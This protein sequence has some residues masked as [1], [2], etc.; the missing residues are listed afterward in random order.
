MVTLWSVVYRQP[1]SPAAR[2]LTTSLL[3]AP[4]YVCFALAL[5]VVSPAATWLIR[6]RTPEDATLRIADLEW[7]LLKWVQYLVA[8]HLVRVLA[9]TL[10]RG[11]PL[12]SWY[13]RLNGARIGR[14]VYVN[15]LSINDHNLLQFADD[16]VIGADVRVSGHTVEGGLLKT[17]AVRID[18]NVTVGLG[19]VIGIGV[20]IGPNATIGALTLVPKHAVLEGGG[21]YAGVPAQRLH[22]DQPSPRSNRAPEFGHSK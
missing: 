1:M 12:W 15:T 13:L 16:V 14:R 5:L 11:S 19:S 8:V 7:P 21:V 20:Q 3:I 22:V 10:F 4:S 6:A 9:G 17:G 18:R 2:V